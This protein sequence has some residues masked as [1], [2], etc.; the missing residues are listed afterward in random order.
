[1]QTS[2]SLRS[3]TP[4]KQPL[5][6]FV[7]LN[8]QNYTGGHHPSWPLKSL[9]HTHKRR[10]NLVIRSTAWWWFDS[11]GKVILGDMEGTHLLH[12]DSPSLSHKAQCLAPFNSSLIHA[13]LVRWYSHMGFPINTILMI[14]SSFFPFLPQTLISVSAL[15][16]ACLQ[17]L[18]PARPS[19]CIPLEMHSLVKILWSCRIFRSQ[20]MTVHATLG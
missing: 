1:M 20:H 5:R 19:C 3:H 10:T 15:V 4:Q 8:Q 17:H 14:V 12:A 13:V 7:P 11:S 16:S 9:W 18:V 6:S 2:L